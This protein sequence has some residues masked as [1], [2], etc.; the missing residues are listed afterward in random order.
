[1]IHSCNIHCH[2]I[3]IDKAELMGLEDTGRWMPFAFHLDIVIAC[4]LTSDEEDALVNGCTTIFTE[5]G[6]TYIID[7]PFEQFMPM[8]KRYHDTDNTSSEVKKD[9]IEL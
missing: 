7:T 4:K 2:A 8:F 5:P 3:D 1:M 9:D 6:D